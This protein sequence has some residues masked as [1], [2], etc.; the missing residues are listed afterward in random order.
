MES[1][2]KEYEVRTSKLKKTVTAKRGYLK[3][4]QMDIQKYQKKN[5]EIVTQINEKLRNHEKLVDLIEPNKINIEDLSWSQK[6]VDVQ[7]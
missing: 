4:L 1:L 7:E 5:E 6:N 2:A 3:A